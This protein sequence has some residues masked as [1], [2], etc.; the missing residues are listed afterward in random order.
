VDDVSHDVYVAD[1]GNARVEKFDSAGN[2]LVS[3]GGGVVA[4]G[5]D[6]VPLN[7]RQGV[8]V[9]ATGGTFKL[10]F[11]TS[12][13]HTTTEIPFDASAAAV[14]AA[15]EGLPNIQAGNVRVSEA[16]GAPSNGGS[17]DI[18]F[19]G[20]FADTNVQ[21]MITDG[22][23]LTG[24]THTIDLS[25]TVEGA[26]SYEVCDPAKGD[27]CRTGIP[28][29][30]PGQFT[31]PKFIA[32]DNSTSSSAGDVYVADLNNSEVSK[33]DSSGNLIT[34]WGTG[35]QINALEP[36][37]I[38]V[39]T[40]GNLVTFTRFN[41]IAKF[42]PFGELI[43]KSQ[44]QSDAQRA[45]ITLDGSGNMYFADQNIFREH[46]YVELDDPA[47]KR[48]GI[49][50]GPG[51]TGPT[52]G[53]AFAPFTGDLYVDDGGS[54][55]LHYDSGC[56]PSA[57]ECT[58]VDSFG[59]GH[60]T[61][62]EGIAVD[63]GTDTVYAAD[64]TE[65]NVV[66]FDGVLGHVATGSVSEPTPT[67]GTLNGHVDPAGN[68]EIIS[69]TFQYGTDTS[70]GL[71]SIPC[72]PVTPILG[73]TDVTAALG[74]LTSET[75]Y[76]YRL[77]VTNS[78]GTN[79]GLDEVYIPHFVVALSTGEATD[80]S[81]T[82]ASLHATYQ[83]TN[84]DTH[85]YFQYGT[86]NAYGNTSS[87]PP[88]ADAGAHT[89][90]QTL[91]PVAIGG[92]LQDT[93]YHYRVV[94]SNNLGT[95]YGQDRTVHTLK[96]PVIDE[97]FVSKVTATTAD[98][99]GQV[100]PE[101][102]ETTYHIQYGTTT[103]Y[104]QSTTESAPIGSDT[105][106]HP[107]ST[108]LTALQP[109]TTYHY[110]IVATSVGGIIPSTDHTLTTHPQASPFTLPQ[111]R[112]WEQVS[113]AEKSGGIGG[114]FPLGELSHS[115]EQYGRPLQSST[116]GNTITY[117]GEDFYQPKIGSLN[118]YISRRAT[119]DWQTENIT[120]AIPSTEEGA[121]EQNL[122]VAFSSDLSSSV[123]K[124]VTALNE[125]ALE[126]YPNLVLTRGGTAT[127]LLTE[128]PANRT[129]GTFEVSF[130]D[131]NSGTGTVLPFTHILITAND[132]LTEEATYGGGKNNLYEW[133]QTGL[134]AVNVLPGQ[135]KSDPGA[136]FGTDYGDK[137]INV[138][139]PN[140]SNAISAD[141]SRI[142]WTDENNGNLYVRED[143]ERTTQV[144]AAV[145]GGGEFQT[146]S[147]DG[148]TVFFTRDG[149]LYEY[150]VETKTTVDL[151]PSGEVLGILGVSDDGTDVYFVA[152]SVL[153]GGE[154]NGQG[155]HA[156][157][158][159]PN[160]YLHKD[161][162]LKFI[163]T[164]S[165]SDNELYGLNYGTSATPS[166]DWFRTFAGRTA[167]VSPAGRYVAFVS[168]NPLTGYD[169]KDAVNP[170][171]SDYEVFLYDSITSSLVC[172]S[173]NSDGSRPNAAT[174]LPSPATGTYQQR[175]LND[176][177][178]LFFSTVDRVSPVDTN[179]VSDVY[180]FVG[181][182]ARLLSPGDSE[183]E[184]V[185]ADAS[186]DGND[187]FFTTRG[188]L[189]GSDKDSIVDLYD[190][191]VGGGIASQTEPPP[192]ACVGEGCRPP[193]S[194]PLVSPS[195]GSGSFIGPENPV[196]TFHT[197]R[198]GTKIPKS[199][200]RHKKKQRKKPHG[201][202]RKRPGKKSSARRAAMHARGGAR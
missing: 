82:T 29:I 43:S 47:G 187:V 77:S 102:H 33:F 164:L 88:G 175:Y 121:G 35:G 116:D 139:H 38:A 61:G 168:V 91:E 130:A 195:P 131:A 176:A 155:A 129:A 186:E 80:V 81:A 10:T 100:N 19:I 109:E 45:G 200:P 190:A 93:T 153:T 96:S 97:A 94:A 196:A 199:V 134:H 111:G 118:Q 57:G 144:D 137:F 185:F 157:A 98:I 28:G 70:Y 138:P 151:V 136:S 166:G 83:G 113:P 21:Q 66:V 156:E 63:P 142:F 159:Q 141:G 67:S 108:T 132:A 9:R 73:E 14:Q 182:R 40:N 122:S 201:K 177:G 120:P 5:P 48:V 36:V 147:T 150:N 85:Y 192:V 92:L 32:V 143:G 124:N 75:P 30:G 1:S 52:E 17:W 169:N 18:E 145:G 193:A 140:L 79:Y 74:G 170:R 188:R 60:L 3:W 22:S 119:Q 20:T 191:R 54:T 11:L 179:N 44:T 25:T 23:K 71:G 13:G 115:Q 7:E 78:N 174:R 110:R 51:Y 163:A 194:E 103:S 8:T 39:D 26:S 154:L 114:V 149:H 165:P 31:R 152:T 69:C 24:E 6:N 198:S 167:R 105:T 15:L 50:T 178:E 86:T 133:T 2:L 46:D 128:Q 89:G 104:G 84:E 160:L 72:S 107:V 49:V 76:H 123:R 202:P 87:T 106:G 41:L 112:A 148:T 172:A 62:A 171:K 162:T 55:V 189:V 95:S 16:E 65:G 4:S 99:G 64:T 53:L 58:P 42:S 127:P 90:E 126:G 68:G 161:G 146:A 173:C 117:L 135:A 27:V 184:A 12:E 197:Q 158:G 180:E 101:G 37:G 34:S 56:D 183:D 59:A 181:G 125:G